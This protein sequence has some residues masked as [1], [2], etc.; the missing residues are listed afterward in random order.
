MAKYW[1]GLNKDQKVNTHKLVER[2]SNFASKALIEELYASAI[3][4]V[5]NKNDFLPLK[6]LDLLDMASITIGS[7]GKAF[8][9]QLGKYGKFEH[10]KL[11][12]NSGAEVYQALEEN[13]KGYNTIVIGLMGLNNSPKRNFGV[14]PRIL[15]S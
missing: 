1:S 4:V 5:S 10:F 15:I 9:D 6:N 12:N 13:L 11:R 2:I 8:Q 3:T 7:E 14:D